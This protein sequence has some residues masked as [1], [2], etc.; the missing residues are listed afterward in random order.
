[1][2]LTTFE[3]LFDKASSLVFLAL[4]VALGGATLLV[5]G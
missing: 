2:S 1:M 5:G 3:R 4:G